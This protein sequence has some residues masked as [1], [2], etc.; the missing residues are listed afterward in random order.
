MSK[1]Y[2]DAEIWNCRVK[3]SQISGAS[4]IWESI[5]DRS[6]LVDATIRESRIYKS[7]V[8]QASVVAAE[9]F[10]SVI[11]G[12][13]RI[14]GSRNRKTIVENCTVSG[15][16]VLKGV[17]IRNIEISG[18]MR[19]EN[20]RWHTAPR[21]TECENQ[22]TVFGVTESTDGRVFVGC[23]EFRMVNLLRGQKRFQRVMGFSDQT[24]RHLA[25]TFEEWLYGTKQNRIAA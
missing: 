2:W 1:K 11:I 23:H 17:E 21:Y 25:D 8:S 9:I 10:N 16:A 13:V 15:K 24:I 22:T 6:V 4:D 12:D 3:E 19:I 5:V 14:Y 7:K 18:M 20:G